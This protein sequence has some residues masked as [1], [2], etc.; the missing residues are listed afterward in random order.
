MKE[1]TWVC[2]TLRDAVL[3]VF[4][5]VDLPQEIKDTLEACGI[6]QVPHQ[7]THAHTHTQ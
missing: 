4:I 2:T 3:S 6:A 1:P 5:G 7:P